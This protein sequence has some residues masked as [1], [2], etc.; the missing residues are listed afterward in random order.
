MNYRFEYK[1]KD[2]CPLLK[3]TTLG[4]VC[5]LTSLIRYMSLFFKVVLEFEEYYLR[6]KLKIQLVLLSQQN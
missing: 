5:I 4:R 1:L 6:S 2:S 3:K